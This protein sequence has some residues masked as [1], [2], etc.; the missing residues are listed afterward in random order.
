MKQLLNS[1]LFLALI[2]LSIS[3]NKDKNN[4]PV[5]TRDTY[6]GT[7]SGTITS[8]VT[9]NGELIYFLEEPETKTIEKGISEN[10]IIIGKGT[11]LELRATIDN[12]ILS[13]P[14]QSKHI[15]IESAGVNINFSLI[16]QG[17]LG[18]DNVLTIS[19]S[20]TQKIDEIY[21]KWIII[22]KLKKE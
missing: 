20:G 9:A 18:S 17:I 22:D 6:I 3:C 7:Y 15:L 10:E 1:L 19:T 14:G 2:I 11:E 4:D 21:Y 16:G 5:L 8:M 13:I 12:N